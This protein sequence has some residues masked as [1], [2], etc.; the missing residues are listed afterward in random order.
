MTR[1]ELEIRPAIATD[2]P[3]MMGMDHSVST[4]YVWQLDLHK[5]S[6]QVSAN[7][8]EVRLP[9]PVAVA[10]PRDPFA[11]AD[12]WKY[13]SAVFVAVEANVVGYVCVMEHSAASVA[14]VTDLV[15]APERRRRGIGFA[16]LN[17]ALEHAFECGSH[18]LI[19][20]TQAKNQPAIRLAQKF[21]LEFCGYNDHYYPSQD[22]A[23]FFGRAL[24]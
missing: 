10:Y 24:K 16:L 1:M 2:L 6:G 4:E 11:L 3:R 15:T 17:A 7:L 23:L 5:Q 9:R 19:F 8:R 21:G 12:E 18:M 14:W 20:E 13:K 22:V